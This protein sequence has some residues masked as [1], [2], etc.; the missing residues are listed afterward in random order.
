[1][2]YCLPQS[3][4]DNS[5]SFCPSIAPAYIFVVSFGLTA[6]VHI[7][8]GFWYRKF[9]SFVVVMGA[10]WQTG[11]FIFRILSIM[12]PTNSGEYQAWFIL[13]LVAPLWI[14]AYVYMVMG[15]MV[16]NFHPKKKIYGI[17]SHRFGLYFVLLDIATFLVQV[18]GA[19]SASGDNISNSTALRGI[20]IYMIGI[21]VQQAFIL[22]FMI[23]AIGFHRELARQPKSKRSTRVMALLY[24]IY[25]VLLLI[26]IRI[27]FRLIEYSNGLTSTVP[28]HEA[29]M[30]IFDSTPMFIACALLNIV[31]PGAV[32]PGK[33]SDLPSR[34]ER[35]RRAQRDNT[36]R[37]DGDLQYLHNPLPRF[38]SATG[39]TRFQ[40]TV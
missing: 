6:L 1:M 40:Q 16:Y 19:I 9:Y 31:H 8:Q 10:A 37:V 30:Y 2:G 14:N 36:D 21:G 33:E 34:K 28:S 18:Y 22:L 12:H 38:D 17:K 35:K 5:W 7:I 4:K 27:I 20:H 39:D 15:R 29:Y 3:D 11:G 23:L 24:V 32:M 13:I 26:T 25:G